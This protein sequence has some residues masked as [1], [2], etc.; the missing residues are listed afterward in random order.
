MKVPCPRGAECPG[1]TVL[2]I[3]ECFLSPYAPSFLKSEG[4][5]AFLMASVGKYLTGANFETYQCP[6]CGSRV[7]FMVYDGP[8]GPVCNRVGA[9]TSAGYSF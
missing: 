2:N 5:T 7:C 9:T 8:N 1:S 4:R 6:S 3:A